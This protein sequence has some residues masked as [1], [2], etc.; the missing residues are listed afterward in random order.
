MRGLLVDGVGV[1]IIHALPLTNLICKPRGRLPCSIVSVF[2]LKSVS[3]SPSF[4]NTA[5]PSGSR[6]PVDLIATWPTSRWRG[7]VV[8]IRDTTFAVK[9]LERCHI[10]INSIWMSSPREILPDPTKGSS[11]WHRGTRY[12]NIRIFRIISINNKIFFKIREEEFQ[13]FILHVLWGR[14]YAKILKDC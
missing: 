12:Y 3:V 6:R 8:D 9:S 5:T 2:S 4:Y 13:F 1:P 14:Y 11:K 10:R 7:L